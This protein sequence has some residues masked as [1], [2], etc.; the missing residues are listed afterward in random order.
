MPS[1]ILVVLLMIEMQAFGTVGLSKMKMK[2]CLF[3]V[4]RVTLKP[5]KKLE[6]N[7]AHLI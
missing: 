7:T 5:I 2:N 1:I 6:K 4:I 3:L